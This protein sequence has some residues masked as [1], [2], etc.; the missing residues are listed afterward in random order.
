[1]N[2]NEAATAPRL[3]PVIQLK[4]VQ[5]IIDIQMTYIDKLRPTKTEQNHTGPHCDTDSN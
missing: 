5:D 2:V 3:D 1:M 4:Q